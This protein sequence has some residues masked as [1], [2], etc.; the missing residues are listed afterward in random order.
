[1][2]TPIL[3]LGNPN[4]WQ[5]RWIGSFAAQPDPQNP[6]Y[7][8]PIEPIVVPLLLESRI[9]VVDLACPNDTKRRSAGWVNRKIRTG[10][11]TGGTPDSVNFGAKRLL[12]NNKN[13]I[14][15]SPID[16]QEYG[17]EIV[18]GWW[19]RQAAIQLFEYVGIDTDTVSEQLD[20]IELAIDR[21]GL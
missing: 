7:T 2:T 8:Y 21:G 17:L 10:L 20:R 4:N 14:I 16:A 3:D 13:L 6:D 1:M 19:M 15:F 5:L 11:S 12:R 9:I 18:L